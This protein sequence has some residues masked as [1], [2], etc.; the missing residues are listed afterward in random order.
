M[1]IQGLGV[2][3]ERR[4]HITDIDEA[5]CDIRMILTENCQTYLK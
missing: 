3:S 1:I 5:G 4:I 2:F